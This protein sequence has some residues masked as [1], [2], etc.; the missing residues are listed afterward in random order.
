MGFE[1]KSCY[2]DH[3]GFILRAFFLPSLLS[4]G[5]IGVSHHSWLQGTLSPKPCVPCHLDQNNCNH[6][7]ETFNKVESVD[8][9]SK[10]AGHG[11]SLGPQTKS[12]PLPLSP[13]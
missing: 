7:E 1:M 3:A 5:V 6:Q 9:P 11:G 8:L 13:R 2:V 12:R 10:K 4:S